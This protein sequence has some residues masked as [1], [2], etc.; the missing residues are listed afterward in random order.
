MKKIIKVILTPIISILI[1]LTITTIVL[2]QTILNQNYITKILEKNNYKN[3]VYNSIK[4]E[5]QKLSPTLHIGEEDSKLE[6]VIT[7][8][9]VEKDINTTIYNIYHNKEIK[10]STEKLEQ[11]IDDKINSLLIKNNITPTKEEQQALKELKINMTDIYT[12][13]M[14]YSKKY[15]SKLPFYLKKANKSLKIITI[16]LTVIC[17]SFIILLQKLITNKKEKIIN[18]GIAFL[19]TFFISLIIFF[20]FKNKIDNILIINKYLSQIIIYIMK[21]I[22]TK[23]LIYS[24]VIG[25]IGLIGIIIKVEDQQ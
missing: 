23:I 10:V 22:A 11:Q 14:I 3:K 5:Y 16:V 18:I 7:K 20:L 17:I 21:D 9:I 24:A 15:I 25:I 19:T 1:L 4:N 2:S 6:E 8:K 13:H 12:N